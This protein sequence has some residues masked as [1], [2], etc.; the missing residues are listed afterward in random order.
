MFFLI[1]TSTMFYYIEYILTHGGFSVGRRK[2]PKD[3]GDFWDKYVREI[4]EVKKGIKDLKGK[5]LVKFL[6]PLVTTIGIIIAFLIGAGIIAPAPEYVAEANVTAEAN[7][8]RLYD[9][10]SFIVKVK[11]SG[12]APANNLQI[13][14]EFPSNMTIF[15]IKDPE[16]ISLPDKTEGGVNYSF[17]FPTFGSINVNKTISFNLLL[18]NDYGDFVPGEDWVIH[19][20]RIQIWANG[21]EVP[22]SIS[23]Y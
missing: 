21:D 16:G 23:Y 14:I 20:E 2:K 11:N 7:G 10:E 9:I 19:P 3:M 8:Y 17:Y 15:R 18:H 6:N 12:D 13:E 5:K 4:T 22:I 1:V